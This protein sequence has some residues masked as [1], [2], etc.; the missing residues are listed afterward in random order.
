MSKR[1]PSPGRF[2]QLRSMT[3][4]RT[5]RA[6]LKSSTRPLVLGSAPRRGLLK[7]LAEKERRSTSWLPE[8]RRSL[9]PRRRGGTWRRPLQHSSCR[10]TFGAASLAPCEFLKPFRWPGLSCV[11]VGPRLGSSLDRGLGCSCSIAMRT[12]QIAS[13][14]SRCTMRDP[15]L[16]PQQVG[17]ENLVPKLIP[18]STELS[19]TPRT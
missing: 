3:P 16:Q 13:S 11:G 2:F 19:R 14:L 9:L 6:L 7:R 15:L 10:Q 5:L 1:E 18:R 8:W 17:S 4:I 12:R